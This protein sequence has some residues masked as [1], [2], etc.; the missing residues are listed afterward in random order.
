MVSAMSSK[1]WEVVTKFVESS[2]MRTAAS[3]VSSA[4]VLGSSCDGTG[5][6]SKM[7]SDGGSMA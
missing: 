4:P 7:A 6:K 5:D 1:R 2:A 3:M